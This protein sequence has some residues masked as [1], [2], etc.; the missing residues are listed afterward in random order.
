MEMVVKLQSSVTIRLDMF[1]GITES[2]S[3]ES[4]RAFKESGDATWVFFVHSGRCCVVF[5]A[6][7]NGLVCDHVVFISMSLQ[8]CCA[9]CS[10]YMFYA[11][12]A[13]G[14]ASRLSIIAAT[15]GER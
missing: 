11:I 13:S 14:F 2:C 5:S 7:S 10:V 8:C 3:L 6:S 9:S 12:T 15:T 4:T 1:Y